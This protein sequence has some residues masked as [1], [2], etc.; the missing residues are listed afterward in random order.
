MPINLNI[1]PNL[2]RL[3]A[4]VAVAAEGSIA[5]ASVTL[6]RSPPATTR[7]VLEL[8]EDLG[9][10][11]FERCRQGLLPTAAGLIALRRIRLALAQLQLAEQEVATGAALAQ[12]ITHRQLQAVIAIYEG[13]TETRAAVSLDISQP[14]VTRT[15]RGI[16]GIVGQSLFYRTSHG[17]VPSPHGEL[18]FR[19]AKLALAEIA[20][21][22]QD[23]ASHDGRVIGRVSI[24]V[25][26]LCATL[27]VPRAVSRV[28][29]IFPELHVTILEG[30][31]ETLREALARGDI[32]VLVGALRGD[33]S[34][35]LQEALFEDE[36][37]VVSRS[38]H[39]LFAKRHLTLADLAGEQWIA[40]RQDTPARERFDHMFDTV[41]LASPKHVVES[42]SLA[43]V[44]ALLL[45]S[46]RL[47]V[48]SPH[49]L[50]YELESGVLAALPVVTGNTARTIGFAL[51]A[52]ASPTAAVQSFVEQ[53]RAVSTEL[54][55]PNVR[56]RLL[57]SS[58]A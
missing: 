20:C 9:V 11:V 24:G 55:K 4:A 10:R 34:D 26:P 14:A 22:G 51:R 6:H 21:V 35:V 32:D 52:D 47:S 54:I 42:G 31:Y 44:R 28:L 36:L 38:D 57:L 7:A 49:Q 33:Q 30:T 18:L 41:H 53:L 15:L 8:E 5:R 12:K 50:H 23:L 56:T 37:I 16:E 3:R 29:D 17:M 13:T 58:A 40:P 45:E 2:R 48:A 27:L 19:R 25:L 1:E 43:T 46:N 39:S